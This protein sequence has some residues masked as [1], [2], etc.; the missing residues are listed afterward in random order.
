MDRKKELQEQYKQMKPEMGLFIVRS[1]IDKRCL[2]ESTNNIK[3]TMNSI[4]F[5]LKFGIYIPA[6]EFQKVWKEQGENNFV[7]EVLEVL[8]YDKDETKQDY[9]EELALLQMIWEEK[10]IK[11]NY[12]IYKH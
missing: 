8:P 9:K 10:L 1:I 11:E 5:Q 6:R 3:G 12:I 2:I 4:L 7:V